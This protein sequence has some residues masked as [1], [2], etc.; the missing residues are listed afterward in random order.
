M[1]AAVE[2]IDAEV[3]EAVRRQGLDPVGNPAAVRRIIDEIVSAYDERSLTRQLPPLGDPAS[4][5]KAVLDAVAGFGVLQPYFD[6]PTVEEIWINELSRA[7][8]SWLLS[9]TNVPLGGH[10]D[11]LL[12][13]NLRQN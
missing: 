13:P 9:C 1:P 8:C 2:I 10:V 4:M 6:D 12:R 3:R 7:K 11:P 5:A